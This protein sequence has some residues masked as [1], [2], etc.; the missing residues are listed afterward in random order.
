MNKAEKFLSDLTI[1]SKY[2]HFDP[3]ISKRKDWLALCNTT[4]DMHIK[5]YPTIKDDIEWAFDFVKRK[6][7]LP[8]MRSL[9]YGGKPIEMNPARIF[10]CAYGAS[11]HPF[12]FAEVGFLLLA[13]AGVGSS[14]RNH[15]I[16]ELPK[17]YNPDGNR[18][19]LVGDSIEG[20][21]DSYRQL[22]YA[23]LKRNPLPR[24]DYSDIRPNGTPIKTSGG[25]AP[26]P[27]KLKESHRLINN[28]LKQ[29]IGRK[30]NSI[31]C[32]DI[33]CY[34]ADAVVAGGKRDSALI[35]LFDADDMDM[36]TSKGS[37]KIENVTTK[38]TTSNGWTIEF[39]YCKNQIMNTN[40][41]TDSDIST[42]FITNKYGDWDYKNAIENGL[43]P[44]YYV[45]PQRQRANISAAPIR[46]KT[47]EVQF[48]K[49][50]K[51]CEES[52]SGEPGIFWCNTK[53][54]GCNPCC[55]IEFSK[56]FYFCNLT[57]QNVGDVHDQKTLN[58]RTKAATI[59]G[60]C[61]AG[62]TDFH[63]LR[64]IWKETT[65]E[66]ALIGVSMTGVVSGGVLNLNLKEA[67]ILA[68]QTNKE[69]AHKIGINQAHRVTTIKPEGSGTLV[70]ATQ[71]SGI[72][73]VHDHYY[74]RNNRIKKNS[75]IYKHLLQFFPS[76]LMENEFMNEDWSVVVSMPMKAPK[77]AITRHESELDLLER[78]KKFHTEWIKPGHNKGVSTNNVSSTIS[79]RPENWEKVTDWMWENR[80]HYNGISCFPFFDSIMKQAPFQTITE[81]EYNRLM[82]IF[83]D[84]VFLDSI[85][86]ESTDVESTREMACAGGA[87]AI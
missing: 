26:G 10:N 76:E 87:C 72:H 42:C 37:F 63:Y 78:V 14:V 66:E 73:G 17:V 53:E 2:S 21:A 41:Y 24:F 12:Y 52:G 47:T 25:V 8:S 77:G 35:T 71:G 75:P 62:Y 83:P 56:P 80:E 22:I 4:M 36:A 31:E 13:G 34:I 3:E 19:F 32:A 57:T 44:F 59:I 43:L 55:E 23:Y 7:V 5:K 85:I 51:A 81:E 49:L 67:A 82:E 18:R 69:F 48:R 20:W 65:E 40:D 61:Q 38:E 79:V 33:I 29:A 86:E 15:H 54:D 11:N 84:N 1:Y 70:M 28:L 58:E 68:V 39:Q 64:P 74:I 45:H 50:M 60:T 9:Q 6:E 16:K 30:L 46:H 27:E